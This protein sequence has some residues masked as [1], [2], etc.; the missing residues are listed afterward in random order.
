MTEPLLFVE[1]K[2]QL[3][4]AACGQKNAVPVDRLLA[5]PVCGRCRADLGLPDRPVELDDTSFRR[6]TAESALPV[7]VDFWGP[8]CGPCRMLAPVLES[9]ARKQRGR[10]LVAKVDTSRY[11]Q[12]AIQ[13]GV[14]SIPC[15]ILY[16]RGREVR[17]Q[18]GLVPERVLEAMLP[19]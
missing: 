10:V 12:A 4:C 5:G 3:P 7:L 8:Q 18:V 16:H 2:L 13:S 15:L 11:T 14:S 17:R 6:L 9:F 1:G 19:A